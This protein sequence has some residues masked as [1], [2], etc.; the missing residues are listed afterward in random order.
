MNQLTSQKLKIEFLIS[1][2]TSL[3]LPTQKTIKPKYKR[4]IKILCNECNRQRKVLNESQQ[5][6]DGCCK[7]KSV[8]IPSGNKVIDDFIKHTHIKSNRLVGKMEFVPYDRFKDVKFIAEGGFSTVYKAIWIDGPISGWSKKKQN[9]IRYSTTQ[10]YEVVLKKLNNSKDVTSKELN[11]LKVF[12]EYSFKWKTIKNKDYSRRIY[13]NNVSKYFGITQEPVNKDIMIIMPYY[14]SG[15][16][17]KYMTNFYDISWETKLNK[18]IGI[19]GG[20][21]SIHKANIIHR[22]FHSG[23]IFFG[24]IHGRDSA[25]VGDLGISKS[26]TESTNDNNN[27]TYGIIPYMAPEIFKGQKYTKASDIYSLGMIMWELMTGRRPFWDRN[28]DIE[29]IIEICDGL[30]PPIVTNAPKGYIEL[31]KECWHEDPNKRPVAIDIYDRIDIMRY[32]TNPEIIKSS[33]IGPVTTN[34]LDAI[35]RSRP[36]SGMIQSAM[37][38]MSTRSLKSYSITT[39]VDVFRHH[40]QNDI[41]FNGK[42]KYDDDEQIEKSFNKDKNIKKIRLIEN[43]NN[44]YITKEV[45]L[46][47]DMDSKQ[48]N[49]EYTTHEIDFDIQTY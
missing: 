3:C 20:L 9:Y 10:N 12:H 2:N 38:T 39:G 1:D 14:K 29:L 40:R 13:S 11:E 42:R 19:I 30:R 7:A 6:C 48:Y 17:I 43:E 24:K 47:I 18:L 23:N 31:M 32:G 46:D 21:K 36:L 41:F 33:D 45:E 16:L 4:K 15:D 8:Y 25:F 44:D 35:Y 22:D 27:E 37:F 34:N 28:H 26:A 5:I 49:E